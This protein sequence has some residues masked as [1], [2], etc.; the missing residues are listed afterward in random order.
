MAFVCP[1][2]CERRKSLL[3]QLKDLVNNIDDKCCTP[4]IP[5]PPPPGCPPPC[6]PSGDCPPP[7]SPCCPPPGKMEPVPMIYPPPGPPPCVPPCLPICTPTPPP[8]VP[9]CNP[10]PE[11]QPC[12]PCNPPQMMVCY[13]LPQKGIDL[14]GCKSRELRASILY[15]SCD[16][17]K[18]NGLQ[19][20]CPRWECHGACECLTL[21]DPSCC[22]G[23]CAIV[24][25][26]GPFVHRKNGLEEYQCYPAYVKMPGGPSPCSPPIVPA[27]GCPPGGPCVPLVA[28]PPCPPPICPCP[29]PALPIGNVIPIMPGCPMPCCPPCCP[30]C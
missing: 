11:P 24:H 23:R 30:P 17:I 26:D 3:G 19:D 1:E 6:G 29:P 14:K 8:C 7:G 4:C 25:R 10:N 2:K 13:R 27:P 9:V 28:K 20:D 16:C 22:P 12:V 18:R 5:C 21:P 15:M